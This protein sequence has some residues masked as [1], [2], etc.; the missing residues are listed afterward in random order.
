[1]GQPAGELPVILDIVGH[2]PDDRPILLGR[3][4]ALQREGGRDTSLATGWR[5]TSERRIVL[6]KD[7]DAAL[8]QVEQRVVLDA[9][10]QVGAEL[11]IVHAVP[12][13]DGGQI[14]AEL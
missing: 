2:L 12:G 6:V 11:E 5:R 8:E 4:Q 7:E 9:W 14:V 1:Q 3:P 10:V 13:H